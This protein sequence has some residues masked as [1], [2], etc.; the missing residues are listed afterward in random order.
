M[1]FRLLMKEVIST[2]I[3]TGTSG[4]MCFSTSV[5]LLTAKMYEKCGRLVQW[6]IMNGGP[7]IPVLCTS[8]FQLMAGLPLTTDEL[9]D[10]QYM[11]D[12]EAS[13]TLSMVCYTL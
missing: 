10:V 5:P 3:F 6:S 1:S 13:R 11:P 4:H 2:G 8:V 12:V 9:D 7:G